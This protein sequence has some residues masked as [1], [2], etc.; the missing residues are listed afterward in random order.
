MGKH[1]GAVEHWAQAV[2]KHKRGAGWRPKHAR[3]GRHGAAPTGYA[4][5][6]LISMGGD[7]YG[8]SR[9]SLANV[10]RMV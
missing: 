7:F 1:I 8:W 5:R 9:D 2:G 4:R 10:A 6:A 3:A